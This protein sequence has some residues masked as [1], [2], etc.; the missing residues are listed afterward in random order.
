LF[1]LGY[2]MKK[3]ASGAEQPAPAGNVYE[4]PQGR[5]SL[6]LVGNWEKLETDGTYGLFEV[7]GFDLKMSVHSS[8]TEDLAAGEGAAFNQAGID[9]ASLNKVDDAK[10]GA[11]N[12]N[13]YSL[14]EG[15]GVSTLCQVAD[16]VTY[17][18]VFTGAQDLTENP[19]EHVFTTFEGFTIAGHETTLPTTIEDF[20]AYVNSFV[21]ELPPGLSI[22]IT[23]GG[24]P[25]Y[26]K[27]FGMAD[28][29]KEMIS[30]PD[31]V[32]M[33]GSMTKTVTGVAIMQLVDQGLVDLDAPASDYL[34]Y[35]PAE[36]GIT[37]RQL[38]DHS[39]GLDAPVEFNAANLNLDGQPLT[40]PDRVA[41]EYLEGL[42]KP[43]FEPG[44][45]SFYSNPGYVMLGQIVAEVSGQPF[46][47]Y[48]REHI[49]RPLRMENTDFTYSNQVMIDKA[50]GPAFRAAELETIT[51]L[52]DQS[53]GPVSGADLIREVDEKF[54]W[55]NR[56]NVMA[57]N[58]GLI[59]PATEA[60]RFVQ[61]HLNGGELDGVRI[62]SP[63]AVALMQEMQL[64]TTGKALGYGLTWRVFDEAEHPFVEHDGG[65]VGLWAKMRL[66]PAEGLAIMLM[67]NASGWN[68]DNVAD[69]AANVVFSMLGP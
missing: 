67:S 24:E 17:C 43:V 6:P 3:V 20:E 22:V 60:V 38:L 56:Y 39:S 48:V 36:Y 53:G 18:L 27:G 47:E 8:E 30:E 21:G 49:L 69:A 23:R 61:M 19:P 28:G 25:L 57:A 4:D 29:P 14:G 2:L 64:S 58:G 55:M 33:W 16:L 59:G 13:F 42:P 66:Y 31:T 11:W 5:F 52:V 12:I 51:S 1:F 9:P 40:D 32:Y 41:R 10:M 62:L 54:A 37:V 63:E 7:T 26:S 44:S 34:D 35:F 68:R 65:G 15:R 45:A 50:A 46:V